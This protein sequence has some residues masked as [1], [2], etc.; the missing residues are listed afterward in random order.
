MKKIFS[1]LLV[2]ALMFS[3]CACKV[4]LSD[5]QEQCCK[6]ADELFSSM[7]ESLNMKFESKTEKEDGKILYVVTLDFDGVIDEGNATTFQQHVMPIA[8]DIL[9]Q[10][11]IYVV[12]YL[13]ENG[14]EVYRIVDSKLDPSILD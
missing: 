4:S 14:E 7:A 2:I 12:L 5:E 1:L 9:S 6:S 10:E 13:S 11:D 3:L 8:E